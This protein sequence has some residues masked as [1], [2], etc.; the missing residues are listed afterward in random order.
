MTG[1]QFIKLGFWS[2]LILLAIIDWGTIVAFGKEDVA[3]YHY[4]G[5]AIVNGVLLW[6]TWVLWR[7]MRHKR[8]L[9]TADAVESDES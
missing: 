1:D 7:W 5:F 3:W 8:G 4:A 2:Q 9:P 6:L